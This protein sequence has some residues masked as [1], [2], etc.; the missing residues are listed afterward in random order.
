MI[1]QNKLN[2]LFRIKQFDEDKCGTEMRAKFIKT[3]H[4]VQKLTGVN[5]RVLNDPKQHT[6]LLLIYR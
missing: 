3:K 6:G 1:V 5:L 4:T 2:T